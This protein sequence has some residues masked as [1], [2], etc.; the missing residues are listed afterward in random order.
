MICHWKT[1]G[2]KKRKKFFNCIVDKTQFDIRYSRVYVKNLFMS[3]KKI[4]E[5]CKDLPN[6]IQFS[7]GLTVEFFSLRS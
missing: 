1:L 3:L 2:V 5:A 4:L 7:L 6:R